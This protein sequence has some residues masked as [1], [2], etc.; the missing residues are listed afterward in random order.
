MSPGGRPRLPLVQSDQRLLA[1][2][3]DGDERAFEAIVRRYR[4]PLLRYCRRMGLSD[5]RAED[6]VQQALMRAWI[7]LGRGGEVHAPKAWLYR[8]VHN[9]AVNSG[10]SARE[11]GPLDDGDF[12][13]LAPSAET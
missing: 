2:A 5:S 11:H 3:R 12:A 6:V 1:L 10:P 9:T 13:G 4:R 8:T 7:A